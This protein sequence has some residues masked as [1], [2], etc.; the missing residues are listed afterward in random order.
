MV[1]SGRAG[2]L[3][4]LRIKKKQES[5]ERL[6]PEAES[7]P[8]ASTL[9]FTATEQYRVA[10]IP[11][12]GKQIRI[13]GRRCT[14]LMTEGT[15]SS[16][17][18]K[19]VIIGA[20]FFA[21]FQAEAW[22]RVSGVTITG[23]ADPDQN[24][25]QQLAAQWNIPRVY[26]DAATMLQT[27]QPDFVDIITRPDTHL[28]LTRLA[29]VH[30]AHVIC[31]KPMAPTWEEC[32]QMI[33]AC[34]QAGVRLLIHEN[35][36]WQAWYREIRRLLNQNRL[37]QVFHIGFHMRLGDGRSAE[38]Y[39]AQ[40]YFRDM[41]QLLIYE[42]AVHF[43]DT[44]RFLVDEIESIFCATQRINPAIRG[45]DATQI[46]ATFVNGASGLI[47]ANRISGVMPS[48]VAF[49]TLTVEGERASLRMTPSGDL[50]ITDYGNDEQPHEYDK[51]EIGYKGDS[52]KAAQQHYV[53]CLLSGDACETEAEDYLRTVQAVNACYESAKTR[54]VFRL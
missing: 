11:G 15:M 34:E 49:G 3:S 4:A 26:A 14:V 53:N 18:L 39:A 2:T 31:Q 37:G 9:I 22:T 25:A 41:P 28:E 50:F 24:R 29:A 13:K 16:T 45:E 27:E 38:A 32:L 20:G 6:R 43:L 44:F 5:S 17:Q 33:A 42:T 1:G 54:Q 36:R 23:V 30:G 48:P 10:S 52:V 8:Q 46:Q 19:G 51:P 7:V 12:D 35:W 21:Q 47:D 40:P